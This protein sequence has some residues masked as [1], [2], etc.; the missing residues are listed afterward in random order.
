[1]QLINFDEVRKS[2]PSLI[3]YDHHSI[4]TKLED[5]FEPG[6]LSYIIFPLFCRFLLQPFVYI[7]R[8]IDAIFGKVIYYVKLNTG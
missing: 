8:A 7:L 2:H 6:P 3:Y 5:N 4:H 1:M